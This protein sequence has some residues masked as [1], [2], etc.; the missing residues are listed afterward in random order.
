MPR[1]SPNSIEMSASEE[2]ELLRRSVKYTLPYF[3]VL[4]AK[5][6]LLASQGLSNAQIAARVDTRREDV[7]MWRKRFFEDRL[8]GLD[9]RARPGRPRVF[10]LRTA[11]SD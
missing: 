4:R 2:L 7:N 11:R 1:S 3:E 8:A 9:E 6:I 10:S 5:I